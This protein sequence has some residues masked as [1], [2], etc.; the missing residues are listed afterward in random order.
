M[1]TLLWLPDCCSCFGQLQLFYFPPFGNSLPLSYKGL[2]FLT[3][4]KTSPDLGESSREH[5]CKSFN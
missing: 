5:K 4:I 2:V 3:S 1:T